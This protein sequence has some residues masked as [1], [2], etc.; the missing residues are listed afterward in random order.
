MKNAALLLG[1]CALALSACGKADGE[2]KPGNWKMDATVIAFEVPGLPPAMKQAAAGVI[3]KTD[4][5]YRC[6]QDAEAKT[7]VRSLAG[8][9]QQGDCQMNDYKASGGKLSG[10]LKC[11][12][13]DKGG[14]MDMKMTGTYSEDRMEVEI[15][16][17]VL[18]KSM[19]QGKADM[20]IKMIAAHT[21]D[22][23]GKPA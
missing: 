12:M 18:D 6:I 13:D 2:L 10:S 8:S 19:P 21:G 23:A 11:K 22:C 15:A 5:S 20:K 17:T 16:G 4:T 7:G 14:A 1:L 3:G 9:F